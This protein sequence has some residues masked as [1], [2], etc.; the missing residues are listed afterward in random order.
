MIQT[1]NYKLLITST[2]KREINKQI[3]NTI[4]QTYG[5]YRYKEEM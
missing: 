3:S 4:G 5:G 1:L 2:I